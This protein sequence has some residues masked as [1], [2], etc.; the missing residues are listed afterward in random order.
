VVTPLDDLRQEADKDGFA[1]LTLPDSTGMKLEFVH[2]FTAHDNN[3]LIESFS[4]DSGRVS[5][6]QIKAL[7]S[8]DA[9][10]QYAHDGVHLYSW[11]DNG[12]TFALVGTLDEEKLKTLSGR[13]VAIP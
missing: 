8:P 9:M 12:R 3:V 5:L 4:G 2:S 13:L 11:Q 6:F 10:R 1:R 7:V